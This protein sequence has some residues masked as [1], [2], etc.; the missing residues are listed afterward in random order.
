MKKNSVFFISIVSIALLSGCAKERDNYDK[1][2]TD[3]TWTMSSIDEQSIEVETFDY[4]LPGVP[5]K[6]T[7]SQQTT[8]YADGKATTVRY[9]QTTYRA[10]WSYFYTGN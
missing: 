2:L 9:N 4:V 1:Y 8:T 10:R 5:T 3:G 7:T 6:T